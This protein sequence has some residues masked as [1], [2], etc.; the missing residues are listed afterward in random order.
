MRISLLVDGPHLSAWQRAAARSLVDAGAEVALV[1]H[2]AEPPSLPPV[3]DALATL[4]WKLVDTL[5]RRL[6]DRRE[7]TRGIEDSTPIAEA[8]PNAA[9]LALKP[10]PAARAQA[11]RGVLKGIDLVIALDTA[12]GPLPGDALPTG[13]RQWIVSLS[14]YELAAGVARGFWEAARGEET[15]RVA[16][17]DAADGRL[18]RHRILGADSLTWTGQR[19]MAAMLVGPMLVDALARWRRDEGP[20][21][22]DGPPA[23]AIVDCL[24]EFDDHPRLGLPGTRAILAG[25]R[26]KFV[27]VGGELLA[28][29]SV[30]RWQIHVGQARGGAARLRDFETIVA[31]PGSIWADPFP[32]V[33]AGADGKPDLVIFAEEERDDRGRGTIVL[34]SRGDAG[35]S[36]TPIY[37]AEHHLSYPFLFDWGG[38]RY[39]I[40][41]AGGG[42]EIPLLRMGASI[43]QW[44]RLAPLMRGESAVDTSLLAHEGRVWLFTSFTRHPDFGSHYREL[45]LFHATDFPSTEW[46][47]H[48]ANPIVCDA[49]VARMGGGFLRR[50]GALYRVA[51]GARKGVYGTSIELRRITR[52]DPERYAEESAGTIGCGFAPGLAGAH[53]LAEADGWIAIDSRRRDARR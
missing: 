45:H 42:K 52:L 25:L 46:V 48:P 50:G 40:P 51:Q 30:E 41:E 7:R 15:V 24:P 22:G 9:R 33:V 23:D 13:T 49:R 18:L 53:H 36:A 39:M 35:W 11:A 20:H 43:T 38:E 44:E 2:E 26:R 32:R 17:R 6:A 27:Y 12:R 3:P 21:V 19:R 47:P 29:R 28:R 16:V 8:L 1:L 14:A 10:A 4:A 37:E 5:D 31:P 34:L